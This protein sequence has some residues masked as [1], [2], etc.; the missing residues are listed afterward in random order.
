M[1]RK[2]SKRVLVVLIGVLVSLSAAI[3]VVHAEDGILFK[4]SFEKGKSFDHKVKYTQEVAFGSF[5]YSQFMDLEVTEKCTGITED[6]KYQMEMVF[7][8]VESSTMQ[9]DKMVEDPSGDNLVGQAV[10]YLVDEHGEVSEVKALGYIENWQMLSTKIVPLVD[11]W[12]IHLPAEDVTNGGTWKEQTDK[13]D[14]GEGLLIT[15]S[16]TYSFE[17]M[18]KEKGRNCAKITADISQEFEGTSSTP[19]GNYDADGEGKG[20][21]EILFDANDSVIVKLKG[22]H[23]V[24]MDMTPESGKGDDVETTVNIEIERELLK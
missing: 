15:T 7:N 16:A 13:E 1:D 6:G 4:Y 23:E 18:K 17:E 5:A 8:K 14:N 12:Y 21:Y 11:G 24:K 10:S 22:K 2:L 9:F 20:E 19:M 3:A